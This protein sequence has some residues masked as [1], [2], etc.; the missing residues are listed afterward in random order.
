MMYPFMILEDKTGI[1]HSEIIEKD[2]KERVK[3]FYAMSPED[4]YALLECMC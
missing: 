2:G 1:A 3:E 4:A